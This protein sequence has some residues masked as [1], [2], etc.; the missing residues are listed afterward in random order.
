MSEGARDFPSDGETT[1]ETGIG[2]ISTRGDA[3]RQGEPPATDSAESDFGF[4][5]TP[6]GLQT[7]EEL[8]EGQT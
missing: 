2:G 8:P 7:D 4:E 3:P 6:P 5:S 1:G